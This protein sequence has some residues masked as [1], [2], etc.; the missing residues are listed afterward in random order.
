M[1]GKID[2]QGENRENKERRK[3]NQRKCEK[4]EK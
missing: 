3:N 1:K 4:E 2:N